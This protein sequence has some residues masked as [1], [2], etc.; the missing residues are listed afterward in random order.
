MKPTAAPHALVAATPAA[1][2]AAALAATPAAT[3]AATLA[4]ATA[5][6]L[7]AT[8]IRALAVTRCFVVSRYDRSNYGK[9]SIP[10]TRVVHAQLPRPRTAAPVFLSRPAGLPGGLSITAQ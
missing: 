5:A 4:A 1:T 7:A 9:G 8:L 3:P 2:L 10:V 6:T